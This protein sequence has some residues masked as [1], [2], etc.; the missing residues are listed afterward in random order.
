MGTTDFVY[1]T[2]DGSSSG[3]EWEDFVDCDA[4][5]F[6]NWEEA[7]V[8][9]ND[10]FQYNDSAYFVDYVCQDGE[11]T[12][13]YYLNADCLGSALHSEPHF[14]HEGICP[15]VDCSPATSTPPATTESIWSGDCSEWHGWQ[16]EGHFDENR[17]MQSENETLEIEL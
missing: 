17:W 13:E 11:F 3:E 16:L 15:L 5:E 1:S 10:C 9:L 4:N 7:A 6:E 2:L 8:A 14:A 12:M